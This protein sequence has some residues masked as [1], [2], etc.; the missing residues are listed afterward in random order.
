MQPFAP[1]FAQMLLWRGISC[2]LFGLIALFWPGI[3]LSIL[4]LVFGGYLLADGIINVVSSIS[5]VK[6]DRDWWV[7]LL[8]G[9][10]SIVLGAVTLFAPF[11]T[12]VVLIWYVATW[13]IVIGLF[14]IIA[15]IRLRTKVKGE[16]WYIFSGILSIL[17][18]ALF[19]INPVSSALSLVWILGIYSLVAGIAFLVAYS[20]IH[21]RHSQAAPHS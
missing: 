12:A 8:R 13:L 16:G 11:V 14:E 9:V 17:I 19:L 6:H 4:L 10:F 1:R 20:R 3:S 7:H 2:I 18:G 15:A 21:K 5:H